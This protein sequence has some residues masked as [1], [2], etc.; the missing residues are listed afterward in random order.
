MLGKVGAALYERARGEDTRVVQEREVP[1]QISRET[2]FETATADRAWLEGMLFYLVDRGVRAIR[3]L[4]LKT[5]TLKVSIRYSDWEQA[6]TS[7]TFPPTAIPDDIHPLSRTLLRKLY[8]RRVTLRHLG[9][10]FS[11]FLSEEGQLEFFK[12]EALARLHA[13]VDAIRDKYGHGA[14][15]AGRAIELIGKLPK[16]AYGYVLRTPSLTK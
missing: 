12:D 15:V 11:N 8:A 3:Q 2:T 14:I 6:E 13:A 4:G 5:R 10:A 1:K 16:D 7:V 9:A